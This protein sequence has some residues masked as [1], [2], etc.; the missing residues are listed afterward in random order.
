MRIHNLYVDEN[1][2]AHFRDLDI[3]MTELTGKEANRA[4]HQRPPWVKSRRGASQLRGFHR[5]FSTR[6]PRTEFTEQVRP[7]AGDQCARVIAHALNHIDGFDLRADA[8][9]F[10]ERPAIREQIE[11]MCEE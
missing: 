3:E 1:G 11:A 10:L 7:Q 4:D 2:E 8:F 9:K 5:D 6:L